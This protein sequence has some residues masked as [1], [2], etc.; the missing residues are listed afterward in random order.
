ML[1]IKDL[2][3]ICVLGLGYVGLPTATILA[4]EGFTVHGV[5]INQDL[6]KLLDNGNFDFQ[7][8][9]LEKLFN[10]NIKSK[11]LKIS[12]KPITGDVYI[13]CV[14]TPCTTNKKAD[15]RFLY[16][17]IETISALIKETALIIIEST[18]PIDTTK[19]CK[20]RLLELRKDLKP[21]QLFFAHCPER[22]LPGNAI[23]EIINNDR[24]IGGL[25]D[26]ATLLANS[27]YIKFAKGNIFSTS[28]KVAEMVKLSENTFRDVNIALANQLSLIA[29]KSNI[30]INDV[31]ALANKHPRVNIHRP[32]IG[33][34]GHCIPIDPYFILE[35]YDDKIGNNLI[36]TARKLNI[37]IES[38]TLNKITEYIENNIN[39]NIKNIYLYGLTYKPNVD[40][41]RE[42]PSL[43][44][45]EKLCSR[46]PKKEFFAVDPFLNKEY[47]DQNLIYKKNFSELNDSILIILVK[48]NMIE[49]VIRNQQKYINLKLYDLS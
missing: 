41:F 5:D 9:K 2:R 18:I 38:V 36:S 14:P 40:D 44:I 28:A 48:H 12:T 46:Y 21:E 19:N 37:H 30:N 35:N 29:E 49:D 13:I 42:S 26:H 45:V 10:E 43:R 23:Y 22:V 6:I 32:S 33:V 27:I 31:I 1:E 47:K 17:A 15:L 24:V 3:N 39:K 34:G 25:D 11:K 16:S 7:E 4:S 20:E 8:P